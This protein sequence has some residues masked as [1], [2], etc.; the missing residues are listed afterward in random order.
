MRGGA[1]WPIS[2]KN[3]RI[4]LAMLALLAG[5][6]GLF[7]L[8]VLDR[9]E[10]RYAQATVQMLEHG[11]FVDIRFQDQPRHKKPVGIHWLQ[12]MTAGPLFAAEHR[13]IWAFRLP[14]LIAAMVTVLA[15]FWAGLAFFTRRQA[16]LAAGLIA[17]APLLSIEASIAKTD[18]VMV[19]LTTL[20]MACLAHFYAG[21]TSKKLALLAWACLAGAILVKGPIPLLIPVLTLAGLLLID[22]NINRFRALLRWQGVGLFLIIL[23]PW[24]I[25]IGLRTDWEFYTTAFG[26]DFAPKL[27]TG[28]EGHSGPPGYHLL[29]SLIL[30]GPIWLGLVVAVSEANRR[31]SEEGAKF[32]LLW[33]IPT[34]LISELT[35]TK[36]PHY[37]LP[38]YPAMALL[39]G[40][41]LG[42][43]WR[44][45][46][47][48]TVAQIGQYR[49]WSGQLILFVAMIL[50][51]IVALV[52]TNLYSTGPWSAAIGIISAIIGVGFACATL[53]ASIRQNLGAAAGT[54]IAGSIVLTWCLL[55]FTPPTLD[56]LR[57]SSRIL[58]E[59]KHADLHPRAAH[60]LQKRY[61]SVGYSEP[62]LVFLTRTDIALTTAD[63]AI[64]QARHG[65]VL[66][67]EKQW[68]AEI[69][70][71][72]R[73]RRL[74]LK[75]VFIVDGYNYSKG[76][77]VRIIGS[78]VFELR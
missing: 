13:Q 50:L 67:V 65:D 40:W 5:F 78:K 61:F 27:A 56:Q 57:V 51:S 43:Y 6:A 11:D 45:H 17:A 35:P 29:S 15:T 49:Y 8:P 26:S 14:S 36:L 63:K 3:A 38:L 24:S 77:E 74:A 2:G 12:S 10:A 54:A 64:E 47:E 73:E 68:E 41:A 9:D 20:L 23:L 31:R 53:L 48:K 44:S 1:Q 21:K 22:R 71:L 18:S 72:A 7:S 30:A 60:N 58:A 62:S 75:P 55:Q 66:L 70:Q 19:A 42:G 33:L 16:Y 32:F 34:W 37:A 28:H 4:S 59:L 76:E 46:I 25:L 39:V 52:T 69:D